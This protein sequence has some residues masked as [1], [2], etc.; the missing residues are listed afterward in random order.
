MRSRISSKLTFASCVRYFDRAYYIRTRTN[1]M[2]RQYI[3]RYGIEHGNSSQTVWYIHGTY[4]PGC[5]NRFRVNLN[6]ST[7]FTFPDSEVYGTAMHCY[8]RQQQ[9][10]ES[11]HNNG[12]PADPVQSITVQQHTLTVSKNGMVWYSCTRCEI[13]YD[14]NTIGTK[15]K[16]KGKTHL[17]TARPTAR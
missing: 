5:R 10:K 13:R 4:W 17:T 16:K 6:F 11:E 9:Q 1:I 7:V 8:I 15:K 12:C 2:I 14:G 3:T